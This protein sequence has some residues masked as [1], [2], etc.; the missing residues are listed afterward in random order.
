M[1][2][3]YIMKDKKGVTIAEEKQLEWLHYSDGF[4][5]PEYKNSRKKG[6]VILAKLGT[7]ILGW[8][9]IFLNHNRKLTFFVYVSKLYRKMGIGSFLYKSAV[10][11]FGD[12]LKV[13]RHNK[14]AQFFYDK[15]QNKV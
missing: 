2:I 9:L 13:S 5:F 10:S 11:S 4:M 14:I 15:V 1:D 6:T 8:A 3:K 7:K 12:G